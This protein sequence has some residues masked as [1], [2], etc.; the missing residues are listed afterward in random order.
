MSGRLYVWQGYESSDARFGIFSSASASA[1]ER[2]SDGGSR[3]NGHDQYAYPKDVLT[4]LPTRR[5]RK[6]GQL[7]L[8]QWIPA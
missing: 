7:L 8:Q 2:C 3:M 6:I 4:R 5:A 1:S